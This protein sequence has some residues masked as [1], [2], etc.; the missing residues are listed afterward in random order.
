MGKIK[1]IS[2]S[3]KSDVQKILFAFHIKTID[4]EAR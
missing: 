3:E 2:C 4:K 1:E